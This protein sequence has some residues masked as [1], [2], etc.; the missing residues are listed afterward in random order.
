MVGRPHAACQ[1]QHPLDDAPRRV[2]VVVTE[3]A[4]GGRVSAKE[5]V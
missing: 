3:D 5:R 1:L 2:I 4:F